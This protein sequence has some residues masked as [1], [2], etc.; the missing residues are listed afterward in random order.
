MKKFLSGFIVGALV[1]SMLGVLAAATYVA[2]PVDFKVMVNGKEFVSDPPA[3]EVEG[4][5]YLPL[6]AMGDALNVPVNW[7]EE[8]RQAEVGTASANPSAK[9]YSRNNPAPLNTIQKYTSTNPNGF[10]DMSSIRPDHSVNVRVLSV[11]RGAQ[12]ND[13]IKKANMFNAD[14]KDG[15]EYIIAKVAVSALSI[16]ND[17]SI[18]ASASDFDFYSTNNEEYDDAYV[19]VDDE[20]SQN[21]YVGG[22]AE[23]Y[24]VGQ[25]KKD[26]TNPKLAYG[27]IYGDE[28]Y[29]KAIWFSLK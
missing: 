27:L 19:T 21:I 2:R 3:L 15:Y 28:S 26:D 13:K 25:V 12:A 8:L 18:T 7:N 22:T 17:V 11:E 23:G 5:T 20:L 16:Q 24:V 9:T 14:P 6:R 10:L 4:R 29:G 1:F